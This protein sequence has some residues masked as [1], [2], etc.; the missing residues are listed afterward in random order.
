MSDKPL[1]AEE[2]ARAL[3]PYFRAYWD[4]DRKDYRQV[5]EIVTTDISVYS[6]MVL[7][8]AAKDVQER[9]MKE[10]AKVIRRRK[11]DGWICSDHAS[12]YCEEP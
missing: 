12:C 8:A 9:G 2:L 7:E 6:D 10:A 1:H 5:I 11:T 3:F 4:S